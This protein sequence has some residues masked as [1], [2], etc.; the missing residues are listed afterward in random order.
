MNDTTQLREME[1]STA[2]QVRLALGWVVGAAA[3]AMTLY[4]AW[5]FYDA[6]TGN[7]PNGEVG[8]VATLAGFG[9]VVAMF[10]WAIAI[11]SIKNPP[12][13]SRVDPLLIVD[14]LLVAL[15]MLVAVAAI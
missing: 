8:V 11:A 12:S 1:S 7:H 14:G 3:T 6:A 15:F 2:H 13:K 10:L 5:G 4:V 9:A